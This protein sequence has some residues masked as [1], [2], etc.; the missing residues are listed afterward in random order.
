MKNIFITTALVVTTLVGI[1]G[2]AK[3]LSTNDILEARKYVPSA[4]LRSLSDDQVID[5]QST[6]YSD[7]DNIGGILRAILMRG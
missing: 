5:I 3:E 1:P 7:D 4:S 2:S 6:L